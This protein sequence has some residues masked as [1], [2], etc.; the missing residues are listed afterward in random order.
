MLFDGTVIHLS[1]AD[2]GPDL[3]GVFI[4]S[5]GTLGILTEAT[6]TLRPI[7]PVTRS[8]MGGLATAHEAA[9]SVAAIIQTGTVPAALVQR[10]INP[11]G[12]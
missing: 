3:L 9:D 7:A 5:E 12:G 10:R 2:E 4:G 8:L 1:A 6:V 11:S